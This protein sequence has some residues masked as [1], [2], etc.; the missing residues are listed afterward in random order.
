MAS[1]GRDE[2]TDIIQIGDRRGPTAEVSSILGSENT[3][4][5]QL[6]MQTQL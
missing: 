6:N 2:I 3:F 4:S 5:S 1:Q